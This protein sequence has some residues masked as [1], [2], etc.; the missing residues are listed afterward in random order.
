M[1]RLL[2]D[3][4]F[5]ERILQGLARREP[6]IDVLRVRDIGLS[7]AA[8]PVI[9]ERAATEGRVILTHDRQTMPA[10]V[11]ARVAVGDPVPGVFLVDKQLP[12]GQAIDELLLAIHCLSPEECQDVVKYFPL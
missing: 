6:T 3:H 11:Y 9:L 5:N 1:I 8:D 12:L 7:A 10:F 4:D 2:V